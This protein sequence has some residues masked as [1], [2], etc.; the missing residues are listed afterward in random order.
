LAEHLGRKNFTLERAS[1]DELFID[2]TAFCYRPNDSDAGADNEEG[3]SAATLQF[4]A[5]C[6]ANARQSLRETRV[7]HP[8]LVE[9]ADGNDEAGVALR[10]GCHIALA[11]R[12]AVREELGFTLSAGISTSKLVSKLA[13][14]YGKPNGQVNGRGTL[15]LRLR[16]RRVSSHDATSLA[17]RSFSRAGP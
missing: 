8:A 6:D 4:R 14:S 5:D 15:R 9:A 10:L 17:R 16:S 12:R 3:D 7:C 11:A 13:A 2:V 1:I